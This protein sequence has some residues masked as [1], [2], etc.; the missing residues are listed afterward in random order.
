MTHEIRTPLNSIV[1]F[2]QVIS[3]QF[4]KDDEI[5]EFANLIEKNS[6]KLLK[7]IDDVL[8]LSDLESSEDMELESTNIHICCEQTLSKIQPYISK[9][10]SLEF[11]PGNS[12]LFIHTNKEAVS[13]ILFNLLHNAAKF[14][15]KGKITL[16]YSLSEAKDQ[17][18]ISVTDTGIGIP[19]DKQEI[20]FERFTK[21]SNFSQGCGLGLALSKLLAQK[22]GGNLVI[23]KTNKTGSRFV[24]TLPVQ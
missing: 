21:V 4:K 24:L 22:L 2:S 5:H 11:H 8:E 3:S 6:D 20:I 18:S 23:D 9:D 15:E 13:K 1:G 10:V 17:I 19:A 14:T 12:E 16:A 7:L